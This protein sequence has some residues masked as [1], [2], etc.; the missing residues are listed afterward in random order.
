MS[1]AAYVI[2]AAGR[3]ARM[4]R[5][6]DELH[7]AL[8]PLRQ[9]AILTHLIELGPP[10][11]DVVICVGYRAEQLRDYMTLAHPDVRVTWVDVPDWDQ[12][13]AG[14]GTSLLRARDVVG[15]R[16]MALSPCDTIWEPDLQMWARDDSW[17]GYA[18][19][20]A[21]SPRERWCRLAV[22]ASDRITAVTDKIDSVPPPGATDGV[23]TGL[24]RIARG[25]LA[26][27]WSGIESGAIIS[28][29][30]QVS[31]G[32]AHLANL[33]Q[34]SGKR[35]NWT[36]TGDMM[37][38]RR[39]II[40]HDGY[41]WSKS[42]EATWV[43]SGTGRVIK[44]NANRDVVKRVVQRRH[45]LAG[46][47]VHSGIPRIIAERGEMIALGYVTGI[48]GYEALK[49]EH[50]FA[51]LMLSHAVQSIM[52]PVTIGAGDAV[53]ACDD[54]YRG[55]T[56]RRIQLLREPLRALA[57]EVYQQIAWEEV[58][59]HCRPV[60]FHGDFNL[61]NIIFDGRDWHLIDWRD[62]FVDP[63]M[64]QLWGDQRYDAAKFLAGMRVRWDWARRGDM[65]VWELGRRLY[66]HVRDVLCAAPGT[67]EIGVLSLL[68]SAPLHESPLDEVLVTRAAEWMSELR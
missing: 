64:T 67:E 56:L 3:G 66:P 34:L 61:G 46:D 9:K 12:P 5:I 47:Q 48:S 36:D 6:G 51:A 17:A 39:A 31:G 22:D 26:A 57:A 4:G 54:F 50:D 19:L 27:F 8:L 53:V 7:K 18:P 28:R 32:L 25:D 14:P 13:G 24:A 60:R 30:R 42:N 23:F 11:A 2:H 55:K 15:D 58:L 33:G 45:W 52:R 16:S 62:T 1:D 65:T 20:P 43:L 10:G 59:P 38:Y 35:I 29:E 41:D 68:S 21:G 44:W 49:T 40:T 63:E 37:A